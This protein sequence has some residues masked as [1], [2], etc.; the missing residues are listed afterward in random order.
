[1]RGSALRQSAMHYERPKMD[2]IPAACSGG[3]SYDWKA[4]DLRNTLTAST[5]ASWS[6]RVNTEVMSP[7][8]AGGQWEEGWNVEV[9]VRQSGNSAGTKDAVRGGRKDVVGCCIP[10]FPTCSP[11]LCCLMSMH[12]TSLY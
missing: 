5:F 10:Q 3:C 12:V 6:R 7:A 2:L 4:A 1:M 8:G 11:Q 9:F